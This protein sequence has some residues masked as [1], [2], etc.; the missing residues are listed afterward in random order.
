MNTLALFPNGN[1]S[2]IWRCC[3]MTQLKILLLMDSLDGTALMQRAFSQMEVDVFSGSTGQAERLLKSHGSVDLLVYELSS[4]NIATF[5]D[6]CALFAQ[7]GVEAILFVVPQE[8]L[9]RFALPSRSN[10]D[11]LVRGASVQECRLRLTRLLWPNVEQADADR[12]VVDGMIINLATYQVSVGG[13][14]LDFTFLEYAL[15]SFLA[16]H[17]GRTYSRDTLLRRVWGFDYYGGSRTVDVHVRRIRAK[18]GPDLAQHIE[19]V[20]G[21]GYLWKS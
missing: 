8:L 11:F 14:P 5:G 16:S 13:E 1:M 2:V 6:A 10:A 4:Y 17:P 20:R 7:S 18:L 9:A 3:K 21:V 15:L 12:I 19:T